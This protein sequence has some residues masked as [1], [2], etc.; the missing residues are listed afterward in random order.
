MTGKVHIV[1][2]LRELLARP[3]LEVRMCEADA[4]EVLGMDGMRCAELHASAVEVLVAR[5]VA[6]LS[7]AV[8]RE[9]G[10]G[11]RD[12][13]IDADAE[14]ISISQAAAVIRPPPD[15]VVPFA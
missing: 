14:S 11:L 5:D 9:E 4:P 7:V 12:L 10:N 3:L 6:D 2:A 1:V 8:A 15:A 13:L